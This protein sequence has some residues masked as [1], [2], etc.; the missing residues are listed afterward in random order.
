MSKT[1]PGLAV[2]VPTGD[3][4]ADLENLLN[5]IS[6]QDAAPGQI[7][8]VD[9]GNTPLGGIIEKFSFS[10]ISYIRIKPPSLTAQRNIGL[11]LLNKDADVVAFFDDD[12][13]LCEGAIKHVMDY[14]AGLPHDAGGIACNNIS[15]PRPKA[16]FMEKFFLVGGDVPGEILAS[17]FQTKLCSL[18]K[19]R[20]VRWLIGGATFWKRSV[21]REYKFDEWYCGYA[22]CEDL[23]F[24]YAVSKKYKLFALEKAR[25]LHRTRPIRKEREYCMGK[26]QAVNRVYFVKKHKEFSLALCY[27][28][29]AGLFLKNLFLGI[30][31]LKPGYL[32]RGFGV[33]AGI[34]ASFMRNE[35]I[36]NNIK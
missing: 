7:I 14:W 4:P 2:I 28:S 30:F 8:I 16:S 34:S 3:R 1:Y 11:S 21:F 17:G 6:S 18:D 33:L 10:E 19:D 35:Q 12:I 25:F 36:K 23:D 26:M 13:I 5:S 9:S 27:W 32:F 24:S 15:H 22:H 31:C 29:C 20:E